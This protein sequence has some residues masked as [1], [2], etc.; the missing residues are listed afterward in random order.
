MEKSKIPVETV[1]KVINLLDKS[2]NLK[3]SPLRRK[4]AKM[5]DFLTFD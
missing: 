5:L 2:P 4:G 1:D 3:Y